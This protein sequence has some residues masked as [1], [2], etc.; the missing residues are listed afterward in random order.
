[1]SSFNGQTGLWPPAGGPRKD[2]PRNG[3]MLVLARVSSIKTSRWKSTDPC[4]AFQR[5]RLRAISA[6][7]C[8][9]GRPFRNARSGDAQRR[10]DRP[11]RLA[12]LNTRHRAS[13]R[14]IERRLAMRAGLQSSR[15]LESDP[16]AL[17]KPK[18]IRC[19]DIA[20]WLVRSPASDPPADT[21]GSLR[22]RSTFKA[23]AADL[24][25]AQRGGSPALKSSSLRLRI[26][27]H[28]L[29][30]GSVENQGFPRVG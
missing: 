12:R 4:R 20:L 29:S 9:A 3:P 27:T 7:S 1:M 10:R 5:A 15:D 25:L 8:S 30:L 21:R 16:A 23:H 28:R 24:A 22:S 17:E 26:S 11:H 14:F 6:R 13:R 2:Q 19:L 18:R